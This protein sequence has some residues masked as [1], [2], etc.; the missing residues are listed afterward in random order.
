MTVIKILL[1]WVIER[2]FIKFSTDVGIDSKFARILG[3][4]IGFEL[5]MY[6]IAPAMKPH[7]AK[8]YSKFLTNFLLSIYIVVIVPLCI[9]IVEKI[10]EKRAN[11]E[12]TT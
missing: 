10:R 7:M 4:F 8:I 5:I 2:R 11:K 12:I 6:V 3:G 9:K 1:S